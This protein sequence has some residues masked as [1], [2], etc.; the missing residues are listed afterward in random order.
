MV[1]LGFLNDIL[2]NELSTPGGREQVIKFLTSPEGTA[3]LQKFFESP[4][5]RPLAG[6]LLV[7]ILKSLGVPDTVTQSMRQYIPE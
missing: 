6:K 1:D 3:I 5:A 4:E 7:P 2:E